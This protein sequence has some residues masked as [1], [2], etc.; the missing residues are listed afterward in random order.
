VLQVIVLYWLLAQTDAAKP[1]R[2]ACTSANQG[3]LWPP[4]ANQ[5]RKLASKLARCGELAMCTRTIW[6]YHWDSLTVRADQL[7]PRA[8]FRKPAECSE[9]N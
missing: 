9:K 2:P 7:S 1:E 5:D 3:E 8:N 4:E 6:R